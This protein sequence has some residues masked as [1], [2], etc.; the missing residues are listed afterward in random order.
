MAISLWSL[1][2][3]T[4]SVSKG[5]LLILLCMSI[6][7]WALALYKRT[8]M[9]AKIKSLTQAK[10]LF[11]KTRGLDDLLA[12][13]S[14]IQ[15]TFAGELV[16]LFLNDFKKLLRAYD[17]Q[18]GAVNDR[19]WYLLQASVNQRIDETLSKEESLLSFLSVATAA[20]P[21]LGLFGTV[22]GLIHAFTAIAEQ[23]SADIAA[24]A[25][26]IAEA[27][28]TTLAGLLVAIPGLMLYMYLLSKLKTLEHEIVDLADTSLW[29]MRGVISSDNFSANVVTKSSVTI[30][31]ELL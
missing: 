11:Q 6:M 25:P 21:L 20:S 5:V 8:E 10:G 12:R 30:S 2:W 13:M 17:S 15:T 3:A 16:T 28:I 23:R 22:W 7:C 18:T 26:G 1:I 19:D 4:D 14:V 24:V 27:L 31:Q 29:I 9:N